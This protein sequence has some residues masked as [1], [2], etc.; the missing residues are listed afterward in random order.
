MNGIF[1]RNGGVLDIDSPNHGVVPV[2]VSNVT[3]CILYVP[4]TVGCRNY[5]YFYFGNNVLYDYYYRVDF[6]RTIQYIIVVD[7][8]GV[9]VQSFAAGCRLQGFEPGYSPS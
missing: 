3:V 5:Y 6:L 7:S 2:S 4:V 9:P 1:T 8:S